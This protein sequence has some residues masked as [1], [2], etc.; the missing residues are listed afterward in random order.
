MAQ[1]K[2]TNRLLKR[3][4]DE[5]VPAVMKE[6]GYHSPM[7]VPRLTKVV[8]SM[9]VGEAIKT[10]SLLDALCTDLSVITGQK[11]IKTKA[12]KSIAG[13]KVRAGMEIGAKVTLRKERMY[14]FV[15][16]FIAVTLPRVKDFRGVSS[17]SFDGFGNYSL[18][19]EEQIVFPEI[20]YDK[21]SQIAG[22][23]IAF[24]TTAKTNEMGYKL[25]QKMGMP[26]AKK[27]A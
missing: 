20:N 2:D 17:S 8:V 6:E 27:R 10:K 18:G 4:K 11:P 23:N 22:M 5:V 26:F 14:E 13:F 25:L 24:V 7:Q 12:K 9:G 19:L 15:D 21:I 3:Y 16:R 1:K